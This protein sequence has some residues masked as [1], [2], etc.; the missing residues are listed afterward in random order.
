[1]KTQLFPAIA[2]IGLV[3]SLAVA[4]ERTDEEDQGGI[5]EIQIRLAE[6]EQIDVTAEKPRVDSQEEIDAEIEDILRN[7]EL[8][9]AKD[10]RS[11]IR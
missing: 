1:M 8:A 5:E 9:D 7:A 3:C 2:A 10:D 11:S 4:D 6:M